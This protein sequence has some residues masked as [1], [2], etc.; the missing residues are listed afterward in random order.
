MD[1]HGNE[2]SHSEGSS[3][4]QALEPNSLAFQPLPSIDSIATADSEGITT[5]GN[6]VVT[7]T[8]SNF[9]RVRV[10]LRLMD[11]GTPC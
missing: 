10:E 3:Q 11:S 9:Q 7:L 4:V 8:G 1:A 2:G 5:A 6:V